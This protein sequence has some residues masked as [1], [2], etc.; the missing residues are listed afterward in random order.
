M[1]KET[2]KG[3]R[4]NDN[5]PHWGLVDFESLLPLVQVLEFG[6]KKYTLTKN[7][8]ILSLFQLC[9]KSE[10]VKNVTIVN[11]LSH[12]DFVLPVIEKKQN[13]MEL[14]PDVWSIGQLMESL[15][16][17]PVQ[18]MKE[19][20]LTQI[21]NNGLKRIKSI[22]EVIQSLKKEKENVIDLEI[23]TQYMWPKEKEK[24]FFT[25]LQ[26]MESQKNFISKSVNEVVK[27]VEDWKGYTL[28][29][30]IKQEN[31]EVFYV[32]NA[33]TPLDCLMTMYNFLKLQKFTYLNLKVMNDKIVISGANNWKMGLDKTE[34]L[35]S[36]QRH[37]IEL[38]K[39]NPKDNDST[40]HH[41]GHIM[42]NAMFYSYFDKENR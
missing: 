37:L 22:T 27:Y 29:T 1:E 28:T 32:V 25:D 38:F 2:N 6:A 26:T 12:E 35:E 20:T 40:L 3:L 18:N 23:L 41:V 16:A 5:K 30:V 8:D 11:E 33:T 10:F 39:G 13:S 34:I 4:Y 36:M 14:V 7:L 42:A 19:L 17:E 9:L 24:V 15:C 21:R 31:T